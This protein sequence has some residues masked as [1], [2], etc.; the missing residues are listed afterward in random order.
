MSKWNT[1]VSD[2]A[3]AIYKLWQQATERS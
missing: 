3:Y 2:V 1:K